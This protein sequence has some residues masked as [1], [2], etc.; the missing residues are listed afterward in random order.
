M[1]GKAKTRA[2]I[3]SAPSETLLVELATSSGVAWTAEL[4]KVGSHRLEPRRERGP[5]DSAHGVK[6]PTSQC[7][8]SLGMNRQDKDGPPFI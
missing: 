3:S 4:V 7:A 1:R 6:E 5:E 2:T 8:G